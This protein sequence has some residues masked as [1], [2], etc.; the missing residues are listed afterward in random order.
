MKIR[1]AVI[2]LLLAMPAAA[3]AQT[4]D[5]GSLS[6]KAMNDQP[7]HTSAG[8]TAMP[9]AKPDSGSLSE[10]AMNDQPGNS[11]KTGTSSMPTAKP[12][13]GSLSDKAMK[14]QLGTR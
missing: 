5:S 6:T 4:S 14:D 9:T 11:S 8:S 1:T 3:L 12:N 13:S 7:G 2:A 10:K